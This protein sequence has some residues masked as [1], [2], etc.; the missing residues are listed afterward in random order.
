MSQVKDVAGTALP[1]AFLAEEGTGLG[2]KRRPKSRLPASFRSGG[3]PPAEVEVTVELVHDLLTD[4]HPDL[5]DHDLMLVANGWDNVI[6]R[7]GPDLAARLPRRQLAAD[8]VI[9]EQRWLPSLAKGLP[10]PI[11]APIRMGR[12]GRSYPWAWTICP[13]FDGEVASDVAVANPAREADRLGTFV[14][15]FHRPAPPDAP[16]NP[17][18]DLPI[19]E[20]APRIKTNLARFGLEHRLG[21]LVD[22]LA[23]APGWGGQ[24]VWLHGD[25]HSAN[26]VVAD[27]EIVAVLDLGDLTSGDPA[28]DLAVAWMLFDTENRHRFRVAAGGDK[29]VDEATWDRARLWGIHFALI[30]L[31]HSGDSQRFARMGDR[32]LHATTIEEVK[33]PIFT[34]RRRTRT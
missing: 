11:A 25:L 14:H 13:W 24:P 1:C 34:R 21:G 22:T 23:A 27:G 2:D 6:V 19:A 18:R 33:S 10:I 7:I 28:V 8:L 17:Y 12:P 4:Q 26:L 20:L 3:V 32:L 29:P 15:A 5:A 31:L 9:N 30:Y 16:H